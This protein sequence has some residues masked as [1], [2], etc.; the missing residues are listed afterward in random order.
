MLRRCGAGLIASPWLWRKRYQTSQ[1]AGVGAVLALWVSAV[2][3]WCFGQEYGE[4]AA[5]Y[6]SLVWGSM[7]TSAIRSSGRTFQASK[8]YEDTNLN[9]RRYTYGYQL[10]CTKYVPYLCTR[11]LRS[12][13]LRVDAQGATS[14]LQTLRHCVPVLEDGMSDMQDMELSGHI[15]V[16]TV[17]SQD[18]SRYLPL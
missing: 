15:P 3:G 14:C 17:S 13:S 5:G 7:W 6:G 18:R 10:Q 1:D 12:L 2:K 8:R 16:V 4:W 11:S 9:L